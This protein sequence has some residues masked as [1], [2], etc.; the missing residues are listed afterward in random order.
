MPSSARRW[1][2]SRRKP[3][4]LGKTRAGNRLAAR[5]RNERGGVLSR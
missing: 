3:P 4:R 5:T 1:R 2:N